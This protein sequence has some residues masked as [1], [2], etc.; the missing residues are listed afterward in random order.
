MVFSPSMVRCARQRCAVII[1]CAVLCY[2]ATFIRLGLCWG[3]SDPKAV[4][5]QTLSELDRFGCV[6]AE[7]QAIDRV[8]R[9]GQEHDVTVHRLYMAGSYHVPHI[10]CSLSSPASLL[11]RKRMSRRVY[12]FRHQFNGKCYTGLPRIIIVMVAVSLRLQFIRLGSALDE[13]IVGCCRHCR[14]EYHET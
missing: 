2:E 4:Q 9:I 8:H 10:H 1:C 12:T 6:Q 11:K 7:N 3:T 14:I 13:L 5:L